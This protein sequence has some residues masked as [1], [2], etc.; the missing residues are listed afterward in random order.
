MVNV[1]AA[2][3]TKSVKATVSITPPQQPTHSLPRS[4]TT[5]SNA[6]TLR[7]DAGDQ[8]NSLIAAVTT[9]HKSDAIADVEIISSSS[10]SV[11]KSDAIPDVEIIHPSSLSKSVR[12]NPASR[13]TN[14][15]PPSKS[16]VRPVREP[17]IDMA[18]YTGPNKKL[19][20]RAHMRKM[21]MYAKARANRAARKNI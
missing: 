19:M 7:D 6:V 18:Y 13:K 11:R 17:M 14:V 1:N 10:S 12:N 3:P 2:K 9:S 16:I 5:R 21:Q 4:P 20:G 8:P 15:P